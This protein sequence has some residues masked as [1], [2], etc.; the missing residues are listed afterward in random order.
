M[1]TSCVR[2]G[3]KR[4]SYRTHAL[5]A[6]GAIGALGAIGRAHRVLI[7]PLSD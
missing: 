7:A 5:G 1:P 4:H 3:N 6:I 2:C